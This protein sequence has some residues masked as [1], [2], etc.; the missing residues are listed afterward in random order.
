MIRTISN[1]IR[2]IALANTDTT[3]Q[4][5]VGLPDQQHQMRIC[6][7]GLDEAIDVTNNHV[8]ACA[9][10]FTVGM[11]L[12]TEQASR[13]GQRDVALQFRV[14]DCGDALLAEVVLRRAGSLPG[15]GQELSLFHVRSCTNY[16]LPR[17]RMW[18]HET[19]KFIE[20]HWKDRHPEIR[21]SVLGCRVMTVFFMCPRPVVLVSALD[22][23]KSGNIF[24]MNYIGHVGSHRFA[25][26]LNT[27]RK[28]APLVE[29]I[30]RVALS[31]IPIQHAG[32][33]RKLAKNHRLDAVNWS[34]LPF[35]TMPSAALRVPVPRFAA[36]VREMEVE[37]V[38][39]LGSHTLFFARMIR[40]EHLSD[41]LHF[42]M[43]H[44][45]YREW[46]RNRLRTPAM[47]S[48]ERTAL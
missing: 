42:C 37:A 24:P 14:P 7:E 43:Q 23:E 1:A 34:E 6:L 35:E 46:Q 25:F 22:A 32:L 28:A 8:I 39:D 9:S 19:Y 3:D 45:I 26:A 41:D 2:Q 12:T 29:R 11:C 10:P 17:L 16:S 18:V 4:T 40:D 20:R 13:A 31:S 44:G 47:R 33:V 5:T 36:R 48:F 15:N 30:G 21:M 27:L 38:R